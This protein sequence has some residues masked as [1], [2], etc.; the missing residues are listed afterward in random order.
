MSEFLSVIIP[1]YKDWDRLW[2]CLDA[3]NKQ[4]YPD[5]CFE[6]IVVNNAP[7]YSCPYKLPSSNMKIIDES[8]PGSYA[9][10]NTGI[11]NAKGDYLAF[12]DSDCIP[13]E[14][15]I[16]KAMN[17]F[18]KSSETRI[19]GAVKIFP[20][21]ENPAYINKFESI[22]AI[23]QDKFSKQ[24]KASTA[25]FFCKKSLFSL[26][27]LFDSTKFSGE[28]HEWNVRA[29]VSTGIPLRYEPECVVLHPAR[30]K[31][32]IITKTKRLFPRYLEN[33]APF[34]SKFLLFIWGFYL[35]RPPII[36]AR[37]LIKNKVEH[38]LSIFEIIRLLLLIYQIKLIQFVTHYKLLLG[39]TK[40][41]F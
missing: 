25:N 4:T 11:K 12:T 37:E 34:R 18:K 16:E 26:V 10:R 9:A 7:N 32:Q 2:L 19:A 31:T 40:E 1:T 23:R 3:L 28:D 36:Y 5:N 30:N 8:T 21:R 20:I 33:F 24:N 35:I 22:F 17:I 27:G 15:W 41:R 29:A 14:N 6:I 13:L 38:K 39:G